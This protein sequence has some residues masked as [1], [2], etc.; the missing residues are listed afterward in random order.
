MPEPLVQEVLDF[1]LFLRQREAQAEW[2]NLMNAQTRSLDDW[3]NNEDEGVERC[4]I[5]LKSF[6]CHFSSL[7]YTSLNPHSCQRTGRLFSPS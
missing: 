3:D 6:Y 7:K 2:Q 5:R 1:V 4:P